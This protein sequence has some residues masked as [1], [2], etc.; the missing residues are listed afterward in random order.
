MEQSTVE[1]FSVQLDRIGITE[2][3][4]GHLIKE[5]KQMESDNLERLKDFNVW[6]EWKN[7]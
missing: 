5:A 6:K 3:L 7:K 4:I 2:E 1:W